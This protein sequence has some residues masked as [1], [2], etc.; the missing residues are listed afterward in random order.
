LSRKR[1][2]VEDRG[3]QVPMALE[4]RP[5]TSSGKVA[6]GPDPRI[7]HRIQIG[8][9]RSIRVDHTNCLQVDIKTHSFTPSSPAQD[10][11]FSS[12]GSGSIP[13]M[14]A[15]VM[16]HRSRNLHQDYLPSPVV[17]HICMS[18]S[19]RQG[20]AFSTPRAGLKGNTLRLSLTNNILTACLLLSVKGTFAM[21]VCQGHTCK[22]VFDTLSIYN[23]LKIGT[24]GTIHVTPYLTLPILSSLD[25]NTTPRST[26]F[27]TFVVGSKTR[28]AHLVCQAYHLHR[29]PS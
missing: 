24:P 4:H 17:V 8:M 18:V 3:L 11:S 1:L 10:E 16:V 7:S 19:P 25:E 12:K 21:V 2:Y 5:V 22:L 13:K 28:P 14:T 29:Q 20:R 6:T 23:V 9:F 26:S 15:A 27:K